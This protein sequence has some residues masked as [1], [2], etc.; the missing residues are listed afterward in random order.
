MLLFHLKSLHGRHADT[1]C[2]K[3]KRMYFTWACLYYNMWLPVYWFTY[4]SGQIRPTVD[5]VHKDT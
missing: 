2:K 5:T 3:V 1:N 4:I